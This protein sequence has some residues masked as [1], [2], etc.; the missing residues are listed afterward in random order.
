M[1]IIFKIIN[2]RSSTEERSIKH[3]NNISNIVGTS[4]TTEQ[5]LS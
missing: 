2:H 1:Y 3:Q 4:S 5:R